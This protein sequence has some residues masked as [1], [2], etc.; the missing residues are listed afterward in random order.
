MNT[1]LVL[2]GGGVRGVAHIGAIKALEEHDIFPTHIAGT[3]AGAIVGALYANG[4]TWQ[5]ILDFFK[6]VQI[7]KIDNFARNKPGFINTEKLYDSFKKILIKDDF[8]VLNKSL[9]ITAT[10]ILDGSLKIFT[11]GELIKPILASAAFPGIFTP[12]QIGE[13][14]FVDGGTLNNFPVDLIVHLCEHIIGVYVNPFEALN[15]K[16]MK[17]SYDVLERAFRIKT[18]HDSIAKFKDCDI[19][20]CPKE[21]KKVGTFSMK[22]IDA[23]FELGYKAAMDEISKVNVSELLDS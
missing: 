3:S 4:N 18:A 21:L 8:N 14:Y 20:I 12:I 17:H 13:E 22:D 2:S 5:E 10:N 6:T 1:G 19:V 15:I 23:A 9:L 7:F 16:D 11:E